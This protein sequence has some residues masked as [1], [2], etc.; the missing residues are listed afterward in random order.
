M[1]GRR[2][3]TLSLPQ[4]I[5]KEVNEIAK[6][7][8]LSKSELFRMAITDFI[9]RMKWNKA[10]RFGQKVAREMKITEKDIEDIVHEF[11]KR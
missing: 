7:E 6:E 10:A 4:S 11:R 9:G 5:L 3:L 1:N 8:K 2:I